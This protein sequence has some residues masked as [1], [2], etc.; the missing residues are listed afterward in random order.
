MFYALLADLTLIAHLGFILFAVLG[1]L[2]VLIWRWMMWIHIPSAFWAFLIEA[3]GWI[4]PLTPLEIRLR[5][6][7]GQEGFNESFVAH[8]I[9][10]VVYPSWLTR[11][12]Q[13][14][15]ALGVVFINLAVY[16]MIFLRARR[17]KAP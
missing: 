9:L 3:S 16:G 1:G 17:K 6:M 5:I 13:V 4:C 7:A 10:P 12:T 2:L 11:E 14:A 15:L 8:Y